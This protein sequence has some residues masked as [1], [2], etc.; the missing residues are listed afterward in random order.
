MADESEALI[1]GR[2]D[3]ERALVGRLLFDS[4][5]VILVLEIVGSSD[6]TAGPVREVFETLS[7]MYRHDERVSPES[8]AR[9]LA[10]RFP[11]REWADLL[12]GL[13]RDACSPPEVLTLACGI[14]QRASLRRDAGNCEPVAPP[15][16]FSHQAARVGDE[17]L[18]FPGAPGGFS[19]C[20]VD[21]GRGARCRGDLGWGQPDWW[22]VDG[23]GAVEAIDPGEVHWE[24][25]RRQR[26]SMEG[27]AD[28]M[29]HTVGEPEWEVFHPSRHPHLVRPHLYQW[30]TR[31]LITWNPHPPTVDPPPARRPE[32]RPPRPPVPPQVPART[33]L[34][35]HFDRDDVL[36]YV[37]V[38]EALVVRGKNHARSSSWA[39]FAV[40]AEVRWFPSR[41]DAERAE[42][43]AIEAE[44]PLFN[45]VHN[46]TPEA[47]ARLV[48]YL[49]ANGRTDL[50]SPAV[51]RG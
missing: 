50:L 16:P 43:E 11:T 7:G 34:Y 17:L 33:A 49:V 40:R 19:R 21:T 4:R 42:R 37:G 28:P 51:S 41:Q 23:F 24:R 6:F 29:A 39:E 15:H 32:P 2:R 12:G 27:H 36:L 10:A 26:C 13:C 20:I 8:V 25:W 45:H 3:P 44:R 38:T 30:T 18:I 14:R 5:E 1:T 48:E 31:G 9:A 47:R 46:D 22:V 35:W